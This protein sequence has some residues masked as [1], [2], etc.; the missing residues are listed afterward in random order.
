[1]RSTHLPQYVSHD[2]SVKITSRGS[3]QGWHERGVRI[4]HRAAC[5]GKQQR[6]YARPSEESISALT[7]KIVALLQARGMACA[8]GLNPLYTGGGGNLRS[9]ASK[10]SSLVCSSLDFPKLQSPVPRTAARTSAI[11][12]AL[13]VLGLPSPKPSIR[14]AEDTRASKCLVDPRC[15]FQPGR[16]PL[17]KRAGIQQ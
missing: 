10:L 17:S 14:V 16:S 4:M 7:P 8:P 3:K 13:E 15:R 1:M 6:T 9:E 12:L 5:T 2:Y 11:G